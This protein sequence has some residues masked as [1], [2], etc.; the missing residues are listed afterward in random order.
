MMSTLEAT[1]EILV[2]QIQIMVQLS[3]V[4]HS[5]EKLRDL[6]T[7]KLDEAVSDPDNHR[8]YLDYVLSEAKRSK[9]LLDA[10]EIYLTTMGKDLLK[11]T[12]LYDSTDN[13]ISAPTVLGNPKVIPFKRKPA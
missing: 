2:T 12:G 7:V 5:L 8:E 1:N 4:T 6:L 11:D 13:N 9:A 3:E 10:I